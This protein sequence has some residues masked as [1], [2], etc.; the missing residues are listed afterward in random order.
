[1]SIGAPS[2]ESGNKRVR[3]NDRRHNHSD[4][5]FSTKTKKERSPNPSIT[6][7]LYHMQHRALPLVQHLVMTE[8]V[9]ASRKVVLLLLS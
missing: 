6:Y 4:Q 7:G 2:E 9:D 8:Q 3:D 5:G 1:M